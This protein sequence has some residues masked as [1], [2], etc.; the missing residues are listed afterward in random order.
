MVGAMANVIR[1]E[2]FQAKEVTTAQVL[3]ETRPNESMSVAAAERRLAEIL[4]HVANIGRQLE[5]KTLQRKRR[6]TSDPHA[7]WRR[8]AMAAR[9]E[10][11]KEERSLRVWI[12]K[13][14]E[15]RVIAERSRK[16]HDELLRQELDKSTRDARRAA[17][18]SGEQELWD[19]QLQTEV[20]L[21]SI[22][23]AHGP[24]AV[25]DLGH[26]LLSKASLLVPQWYREQWLRTSY[27]TTWGREA[28]ALKGDRRG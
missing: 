6:W 7:E 20:V 8:V 5:D 26:T 23:A 2:P 4:A 24:H 11:Y 15:P 19:L 12:E 28:E 22:I 9:D 14:D 13:Q 21:L 1:S 25:P 27:G 18:K 17:R 10:L 3:E 16:R